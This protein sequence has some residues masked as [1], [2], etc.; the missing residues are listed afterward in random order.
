MFLN[1]ERLPQSQGSKHGSGWPQTSL[2]LLLRQAPQAREW[3]ALMCLSTEN[4][5][6]FQ[7]KH[8]IFRV[9]AMFFRL[10]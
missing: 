3:A 6:I 2:L 4:H 5:A 1:K 8:A 10:P 7:R 9:R